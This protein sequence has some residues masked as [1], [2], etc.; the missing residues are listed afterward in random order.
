MNSQ[1]EGQ[2]QGYL[3]KDLKHHR[4]QLVI[5]PPPENLTK[6]RHRPGMQLIR[7]QEPAGV[8]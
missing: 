2:T 4:S 8:T 5:P 1:V 7:S 3:F 6:T